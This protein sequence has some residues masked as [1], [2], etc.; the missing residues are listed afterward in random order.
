MECMEHFVG[1]MVKVLRIAVHNVEEVGRCVVHCHGGMVV[2]AVEPGIGVGVNLE[3]H[4]D[5]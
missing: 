3:F 4:E 5:T 1:S 2:V